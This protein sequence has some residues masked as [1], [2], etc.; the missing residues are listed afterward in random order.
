MSLLEITACQKL[1]DN[2]NEHMLKSTENDGH[3][4]WP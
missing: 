3:D 1:T 2:L 4:G